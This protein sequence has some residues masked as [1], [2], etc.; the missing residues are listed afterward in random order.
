[1]FTVWRTTMTTSKIKFTTIS[2]EAVAVDVV[3]L[4]FSTHRRWG[5]ACDFGIIRDK[6]IG[7]GLHLSKDRGSLNGMEDNL[8]T[9]CKISLQ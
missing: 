8:L 9:T 1:M 7:A 6:E 4:A 2:D 5:Q 3:T